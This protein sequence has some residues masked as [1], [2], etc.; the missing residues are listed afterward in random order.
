MTNIDPNARFL[1]PAVDHWKTLRDEL[2]GNES[3]VA[4]GS[5]GRFMDLKEQLRFAEYNLAVMRK[6]IA[7][8]QSLSDAF[9]ALGPVMDIRCEGYTFYSPRR[10]EIPGWNCPRPP[11]SQ[12]HSR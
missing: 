5:P 3:G 4:P 2:A 6:V 8:G 12:T 1:E 11:G 7:R 10:R 9:C